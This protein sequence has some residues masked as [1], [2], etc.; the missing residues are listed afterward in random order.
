MKHLQRRGHR[1]GFGSS[2]L[3]TRNCR[4]AEVVY[5]DIDGGLHRSSSRRVVGGAMGRV[6]GIRNQAR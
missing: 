3:A 6:L 1:F 2:L 4:M 5:L